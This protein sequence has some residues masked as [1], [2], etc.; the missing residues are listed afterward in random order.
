VPLTPAA[1][2]LSPA[3]AVLAL[4]SATSAT[5]QPDPRQITIDV[6]V[7]GTPLGVA[8]GGSPVGFDVTVRNIDLTPRQGAVVSLEFP[9][10]SFRLYAT[11]QAGTTI[12]CAQGSLTRV[13]DAQGQVNFA[14]R[15]G[16]WE[17][18]NAVAVLVDGVL[19]GLVK[20]RSP[21]YDRDGKVGLSDLAVFT[22]DLLGN[23]G[24]QKSDFDL[25]GS[26]GLNDYAI[27]TEQLL[28]TTS[29]QALCP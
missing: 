13:T 14:A 17:D 24:A 19:I 10:A 11:Q 26:T 23:P 25:N 8:I 27:I 5:A 16:G 28:G 21:D 18:G 1:R 15:F 4:V 6:V 7:V 12:N 22:G 3:L 9:A 20:G 2:R 29:P